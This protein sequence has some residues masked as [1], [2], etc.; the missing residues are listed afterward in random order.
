MISGV[1]VIVTSFLKALTEI[2]ALD[3]AGIG[4]AGLDDAAAFPDIVSAADFAAISALDL[5]Y[6]AVLTVLGDLCFLRA[7]S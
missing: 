3:G 6:A 2:V 7:F 5:E 4:S 1:V